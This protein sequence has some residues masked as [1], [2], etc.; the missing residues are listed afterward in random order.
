M[1]DTETENVSEQVCEDPEYLTKQIITYI[2]NKRSL[3]SFIGTAVKQ[4]QSELGK[5]KLSVVDLFAGSGVVSRYLK[6]YAKVIYANDLE[7]YSSVINRCYLA[8]REDIDWE[9]LTE[10]YERIRSELELG[11]YREGFLSEM[12][13]PKD[14]EEILPGERVFYTVRNGHYLD[15]ARQLLEEVPEPFRTYLMGPLLYE[16]SVHTN[17]SG[18][19]KGFYKN[20]KTKIGQFGG[21]GRNALQRILGDIELRL[22]VLSRF[23]CD[24]VITCRDANELVKELPH[25]DLVYMDP[26]YN[27]HPYGS[28]YFMLNLIN[29]YRRPE[30]VSTVSGIPKG[31]NQSKYNKKAYAKQCMEALCGDI[32]AD[33]LLISFN[34]EGFISRDEM[35][36]M[37]S[38]I[39]KVQVFDQNY[40][41]F[42]GCRNL[43][44]RDIHV[45]EYLYLVDKR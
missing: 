5:E 6:Q 1:T 29:E 22:P 8:N 40:N 12:Y 34:N 45:K 32:D 21:D 15:T 31:W 42:R 28:N 2:G 17:T 20:T 35:V 37:L 7:A 33:F 14:D 43:S 26:P 39:G 11:N 9:K 18:V 16:A 23:S 4:V 27:Q 30:D 25:V 10:Y 44:D 24:S 3:L 13:C 41:T 38:K 19:F 36:E